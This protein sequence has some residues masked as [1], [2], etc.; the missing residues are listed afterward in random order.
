MKIL[1]VYKRANPFSTGGIE[2]VIDEVTRQAHQHGHLNTV[3]CLDA[4]SQ[5]IHSTRLPHARVIAFPEDLN[6]ASCGFSLSLLRHFRR[7]SQDYD[8]IHF[9]FPWPFAD[10][11]STVTKTPYV[12]SY[13]SDVVRQKHLLKLYTPLMRR[14]LRAAK[15]ITVT[16]P[17]LRDT[18][19]NLKRENLKKTPVVIPNGIAEQK[20]RVD[21]ARVAEFQERFGSRFMLFIGAFRY[22]KGID[23]L[24]KAAIQEKVDLVL[25]GD[26]DMYAEA[27]MMS[28]DD[29]HHI[30]LLGHVSE[31]DKQALLAGCLALVLP[32]SFRSEAYGMVLVEAARMGKPMI[33]TE[34]GTGASFIN[35]HEKTGLVIPPADI[36]ALARAM[37]SLSSSPEMASRMGVAARE[38][39]EQSFTA[40]KMGDALDA[41]YRN[42]VL[43]EKH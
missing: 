9:Q 37:M 22:Y 38:R 5:K 19:P 25:C 39:F 8:V 33:S 7:I 12:I 4:E 6:L 18:S 16:S 30:H 20:P 13:Q 2:H 23:T 24:I 32:S 11:L 36:A 29:A 42:V 35:Q 10:I 17:N 41:L 43:Q 31:S 1:H 14:F 26:G 27:E 40:E 28:A 21:V 34:L 15:A 3:L